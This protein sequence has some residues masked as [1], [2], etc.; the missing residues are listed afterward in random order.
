MSYL[1]GKGEGK[2]PPGRRFVF[3]AS[4]KGKEAVI[5]TQKGK[6]KDGRR[7]G[8]EPFV[9]SYK[10]EREEEEAHHVNFCPGEVKC[11]GGKEENSSPGVI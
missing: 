11:P 7:K 6:K 9:T 1:S 4:W 2:G 3:L 8:V 10:R 5:P